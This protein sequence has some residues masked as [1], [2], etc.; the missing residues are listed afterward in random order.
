MSLAYMNLMG[1]PVFD[2]GYYDIPIQDQY[3]NTCMN[4]PKY[5]GP[6][7]EDYNFNKVVGK[8]VN[9]ARGGY[10]VEDHPTRPSPSL[11]IESD[12]TSRWDIPL[13]QMGGGMM[14]G[15]GPNPLLD[16]SE[17]R[18]SSLQRKKEQTENFETAFS[19]NYNPIPQPANLP[20]VVES[21]RGGGGGGG[22]RGGGG[23][24]GMRGGGGGGMRGGGGG[25]MRMAGGGGR[26]GGGGGGRRP[27]PGPRPRPGP[28][29]RRWGP[30]WPGWN[31]PGWYGGGGGWG[32]GGWGG[33]T[34]IDVNTMP[35]AAAFYTTYPVYGNLF[36]PYS[37]SNQT[38]DVYIQNYYDDGESYDNGRPPVEKIVEKVVEKKKEKNQKD[39][40]VNVFIMVAIIILV[41]IVYKLVAKH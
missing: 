36:D 7:V 34:Y 35:D 40:M 3:S 19:Y 28:G 8:E 6:K 4:S 32:Y 33:N 37:I 12:A 9:N 2:Q 27:G 25:G 16:L 29:P 14:M 39:L 41:F 17:D 23:G 1:A 20:E 38:P 5:D 30:G 13:N 11:Y 18:Y 15:G 24:G 26:R 22:G 31:Y 10:V 21:F